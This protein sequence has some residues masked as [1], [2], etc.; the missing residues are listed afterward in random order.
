MRTNVSTSDVFNVLLYVYYNSTPNR[1]QQ[2]NITVRA[3]L[4]SVY[5]IDLYCVFGAK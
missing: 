2:L 4:I 1:S 3:M 5:F